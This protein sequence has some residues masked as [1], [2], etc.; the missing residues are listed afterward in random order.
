M[1]QNRISFPIVLALLAISLFA[2]RPSAFGQPA[3]S[4]QA[5][6]SHNQND[7]TNSR[8]LYHNGFVQVG[9]SNLYLIWYGCWDNTCGTVGD[10]ASRLIL[11][12]FAYNVGASPYFQ[13]NAGYSD[14]FGYTPSGSLPFGGEVVDQYSHGLELKVSDI[15][16]IVSDQI[17]SYRLPADPAGIY[18]VLSSV[19]VSSPESGFCDPSAQPHHGTGYA[20]FGSAFSYAFVGHAM[21]CPSI[22]APQFMSGQTMLPS[23]NGSVAADAMASTLAHVLSTTITNP[24]GNGWFDRYGLQNADKCANEFGATYS[25]PNGARANLKLGQRDYLIQYNWVNDKKGRCAINS[26]E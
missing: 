6:A 3:N 14:Q 18:V 5:P 20:A 13:I 12:D 21:R 16:E 26:S 10:S 19:D 22:A 25:T 9:S 11:E 15:Q 23:P 7:K 8:I 1:N 17:S 2:W 24:R 4:F